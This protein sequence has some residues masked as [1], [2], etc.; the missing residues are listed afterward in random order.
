M[1]W[2]HFSCLSV[3]RRTWIC[4]DHVRQRGTQHRQRALHQ[5]R[6][7]PGVHRVLQFLSHERWRS[8]G[9]ARESEPQLQHE[10]RSRHTS[11][12]QRSDL[13][14]GRRFRAITGKSNGSYGNRAFNTPSLLEAADTPPSFTTTSRLRSTKPWASTP[15]R[16]STLWPLRSSSSIRRRTSRS[17]TS[18]AG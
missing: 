12:S 8:L 13:S 16:N 14:S 18:C 7:R 15:V 9:R 6:W 10:H 17:R 1:S 2:K 11:G 3:G 4:P 5:R